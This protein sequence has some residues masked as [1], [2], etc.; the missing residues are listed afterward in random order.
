LD[1]YGG[2]VGKLFAMVSE[3][4]QESSSKTLITHANDK[5]APKKRRHVVVA[6]KYGNS[7][8]CNTQGRNI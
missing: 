2:L 5:E 7:I 8:K 1:G 6:E 3:S 4:Q